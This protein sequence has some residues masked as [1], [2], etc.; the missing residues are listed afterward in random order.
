MKQLT[1]SILLL[2][3]FCFSLAQSSLQGKVTD[4]ETGEDLIGA[5]VVFE[6]NGVFRNGTSTDFEGSYNVKLDPGIYDVKVSTIGYPVYLIQGVLVKPGQINQLDVEI[7]EP[8]HT[9]CYGHV[10]IEYIV[11]LIEIDNNSSVVTQTSR[12]IQRSPFRN[13]HDLILTAAGVSSASY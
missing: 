11:P 8:L 12:G 10:S 9:I 7:P 3:C 2:C 13:T 1:T 5:N 4:A 6:K